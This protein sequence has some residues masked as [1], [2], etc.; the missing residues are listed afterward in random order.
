MS[1]SSTRRQTVKG[2]YTNRTD[3]TRNFL[4]W[5]KN[6]FCG[7]TAPVKFKNSFYSGAAPTTKK[8]ATDLL[9][10]EHIVPQ[11]WLL[12]SNLVLE[13]KDPCDI[14]CTTRLVTAKE[15]GQRGNK[16]LPLVDFTHGGSVLLATM[17]NSS[18]V[19]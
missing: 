1:R 7:K 17:H 3:R 11:S 5:Q 14:A 18:D 8:P 16:Y 10:I 15:N 12:W 9:Q 6:L 2:Y 19:W 13:V 4:A